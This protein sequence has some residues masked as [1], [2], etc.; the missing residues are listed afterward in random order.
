MSLVAYLNP[1]L[2]PPY[3]LLVFGAF[4]LVLA[5]AGTCTGKLWGRGG[6]VYRA[7]KPTQFWWATALYYFGGVGFVGYFLYMAYGPS[8]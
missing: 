5:V 1:R 7:E 2:S 3:G 4:L 8:N 6:P